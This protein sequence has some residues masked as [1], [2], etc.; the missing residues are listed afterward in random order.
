MW[1]VNYGCL[2]CGRDQ[3]AWPEGF[4]GGGKLEVDPEKDGD[5]RAGRGQWW[6]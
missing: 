3:G 1:E 5:G 6:P 2:V 4:P